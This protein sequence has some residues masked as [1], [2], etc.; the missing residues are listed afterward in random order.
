M[1]R[2]RYKLGTQKCCGFLKTRACSTVWPS[3]DS[4]RRSAERGA[5]KRSR[6]PRSGFI[7]SA[8]RTASGTRRTSGRSCG[9]FTTP[10]STKARRSASFPCPIGRNSTCGS[11]SIS[12]TS[13]SCRCTSP[14]ERPMV[15]RGESLL[16]IE[17]NPPL[18]PGEKP[19]MVMSPDAIARLHTCT[20]AIRS[21]ADTLAQD[22]RRI[23]P[24]A[25]VRARE[26]R[27]RPRSGRLDGDQEARGLLLD[28]DAAPSAIEEFLEQE[29][30]KAASPV[31]H[32]GQR[33]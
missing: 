29:Q 30:Q 23:V 10:A 13:R 33:G 28:G 21:S 18:L 2:I 20:G 25:P 8:M 12:R 15:V 9:I 32:C 31:H 11:T 4:T 3:G 24:H 19:Q 16:P 5:T 7:R 1:A 17:H 27:H 14:K 22:H 6:A 26:S